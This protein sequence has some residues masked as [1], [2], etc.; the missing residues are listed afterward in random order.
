[1]LLKA[2]LNKETKKAKI[3]AKRKADIVPFFA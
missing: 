2:T 3:K 1:M